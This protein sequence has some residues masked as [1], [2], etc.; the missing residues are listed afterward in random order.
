M[1]VVLI[2][3][4]GIILSGVIGV[5]WCGVGCGVWGNHFV[6]RS[7]DA[8]SPRLKWVLTYI[9]RYSTVYRMIEVNDIE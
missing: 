2:G 4:T 6:C 3:L 1:I 7:G 8:Q 9:F 5:V